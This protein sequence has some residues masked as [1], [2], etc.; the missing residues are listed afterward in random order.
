[1]LLNQ[2]IDLLQQVQSAVG[3][4]LDARDIWVR[5]LPEPTNEAFDEPGAT[6]RSQRLQTQHERLTRLRPLLAQASSSLLRGI[7]IQSRIVPSMVIRVGDEEVPL[8]A[9]E[10]IDPQDVKN[11]VKEV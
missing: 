6:N 5:N 10:D 11:V 3:Q 9:E 2:T 1:M 8:D 4:V 7:V